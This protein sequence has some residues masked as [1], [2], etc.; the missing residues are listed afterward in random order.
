MARSRMV[1]T[2]CRAYPDAEVLDRTD[3]SHNQLDLAISDP[4]KRHHDGK[5]TLVLGEHRSAVRFSDERGNCCPNYWHFSPYGFCPYGCAYCY[6]AGTQGVWFS[7]TV[8]VFLN[9]DEM[10]SQIDMIAGKARCLTAFYLGKLQDGLAM[11]PLTG[12]SRSLV[13][14]FAE[15]PWARLIVLTKS[16]DVQNL[17]GLKHGGNVILSW[18]LSSADMWRRFESGTPSPAERLGAM[19]QCAEAG[20]RIRVVIMP[21]LPLGLWREEY[22]ELVTAL[23]TTVRVERIT[24][25]GICS[26]PNAIRL[27]TAKLGESNVIYGLLDSAQSTD[28]RYR[29]AARLRIECYRYLVGAIRSHRP[30]LVVGLCLEEPSV[31]AELGLSRNIGKCNCVL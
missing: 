27:T 17:L 24:L 3:I 16:A 20:Y 30:D 6:L 14:W 15:H 12:Y 26:F 10:V 13:P 1:E 4:L 31:F 28:G 29:F 2:I 11:D 19:R 21:I 8:K 5:Q 22:A 23:L 7:P 9:L 25:G 18:S